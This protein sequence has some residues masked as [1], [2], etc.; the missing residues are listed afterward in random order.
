MYVLQSAYGIAA[1]DTVTMATEPVGAAVGTFSLTSSS[2]GNLVAG[3]SEV[4][5]SASSEAFVTL[6]DTNANTVSG[7]F[8]FSFPVGG[9]P[10]P[11]SL[12][13]SGDGTQ[14]YA[15]YGTSAL[16]AEVEV[17]ALPKGTP[18]KSFTINSPYASVAPD[19]ISVSP[20]GSTLFSLL[21][22]Y[23]NAAGYAFEVLCG[24]NLSTYVTT[25][26][27]DLALDS[28]QFQ[29]TGTSFAQTP[30]G[31]EVYIP[32]YQGISNIEH[33]TALFLLE[34]GTAKMNVS[35]AL[36]IPGPG[37]STGLPETQI[38][39]SAATDS[40]YLSNQDFEALKGGSIM[41][42]DLSTYTVA[43]TQY[44]AYNPSGL[45]ITPDGTKLFVTGS[46]TGTQIFDGTTLSPVGSIPGGL[47]QA[48]V[49]APQ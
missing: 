13:I 18:T 21:T 22:A 29:V 11:L 33:D 12:A 19:F 28:G 15:A 45:A 44:L 2:S 32:T 16:Q 48:I 24:T 27:A 39:Y 42:I 7:Q 49:I 6:V 3:L 10:I 46:L 23:S 31:T 8:A 34:V 9:P 25:G 36:E 30:D 40:V 1:E 26:C 43:A 20:D 35:R 47:Q 5:T 37:P 17:L 41:R 38:V 14:G 4:A